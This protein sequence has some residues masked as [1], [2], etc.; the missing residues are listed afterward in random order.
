MPIVAP[1]VVPTV[2]PPVVETVEPITEPEATPAAEPTPPE[3]EL[4]YEAPFEALAPTESAVAVPSA[5]ETI[6]PPEVAAEVMP[7]S[8]RAQKFTESVVATGS[9][10]IV[11]A[12]TILVLV[13]IGFW[14]FRF[15]RHG[16]RRSIATPLKN[17]K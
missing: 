11:Q 2:V 17:G 4:V 13:V 7:L 9:S 12:L 6:E 15:V 1:P 5:T 16:G 10:P 14:Y 8:I 3:P